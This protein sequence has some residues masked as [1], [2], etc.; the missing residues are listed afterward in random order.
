MSELANAPQNVVREVGKVVAGKDKYIRKVMLAI[1][2]GGHI[3][4]DDI[5]GVG[6]TT[7]ALAFSK[8]MALKQKRVQ[9]TPDVLPSDVTGFYMFQKETKTFRYVPGPVMTNLFLADEINRT[10]PKTQSALLQVM[11][12]GKVTIDGNTLDV[13]DPFIVIATQN[14]TGSAGTQLLPESQLDRFMICISLGYPDIQNEIQIIKRRHADNPL[15]HVR[16]VMDGAMLVSCQKMV[17]QVFIHDAVYEYIAQ[18]V[19]ATRSSEL[20][21][22]GVSPRGTLALCRMAKS[23]AFLS[24]RDYVLPDDVT[25]IFKDVAAHRLILDARAS[26]AG[27]DAKRVLDGIL[28]S[29]AKPVPR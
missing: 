24:G 22:L 19:N 3:L 4:M 29:V 7:M 28:A 16:P 1:L 14:P 10:S 2:A 26:I 20:I 18:L 11:E 13:P 27:C 8:A 23:A 5:P 15:D 9:F 21:K 6:K 12:E 17:E 25:G